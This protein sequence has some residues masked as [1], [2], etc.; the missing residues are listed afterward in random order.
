MCFIKNI[1]YACVLVKTERERNSTANH[2]SKHCVHQR[3][4][5]NG[6]NVVLS[7]NIILPKALFFFLDINLKFGTLGVARFMALLFLQV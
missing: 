7:P 1:V 2:K 3:S 5:S 6:E 4:A